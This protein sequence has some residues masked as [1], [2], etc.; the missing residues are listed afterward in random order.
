[1]KEIE[2]R[3]DEMLLDPTGETGG[4]AQQETGERE[5]KNSSQNVKSES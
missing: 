1:M 4:S 2:M 5:K 3:E